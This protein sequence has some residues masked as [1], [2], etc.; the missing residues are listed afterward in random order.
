MTTFLATFAIFALA[1]LGMAVGV[2]AGRRC[3]QGSCGGLAGLKDERGNSLC[4]S[5]T[6]P[7]PECRSGM[8]VDNLNEVRE[9]R[10]ETAV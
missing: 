5:C 6:T 1:I 2:L 10:T 7:S 3:L 9:D 8:E 4:E